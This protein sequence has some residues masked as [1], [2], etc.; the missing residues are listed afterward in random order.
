MILDPSKKDDLR[1]IHKKLALWFLAD[2]YRIEDKKFKKEFKVSSWYADNSTENSKKQEDLWH[3][4][5][6]HVL[7]DLYIDTL[8]KTDLRNYMVKYR[9]WHNRKR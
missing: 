1:E 9:K 7:V 3:G 6:P 8:T 4:A 2:P 5:P